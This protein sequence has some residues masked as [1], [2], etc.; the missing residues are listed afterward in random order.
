VTTNF[1]VGECT[2]LPSWG[3]HHIT[4]TNEQVNLTRVCELLEKV[5][6][7]A[8]DKLKKDCPIKIHCMI[9]PKSVNAPG[10]AGH[11]KDYNK[12]VKGAPRSAH[13]SG[14]AVD[15]SIEGVDCDRLRKL[16]VP[17]LTEFDCRMESL[18]GAGWVHLD[19]IPPTEGRRYFK[20][21]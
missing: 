2:L 15:F 13:I 6:F 17:K 9:R 8:S 5:R 21:F 14:L 1:T 7:F 12:F 11:G 4:S 16:L 20:P 3:C 18:H 19:L 10:H